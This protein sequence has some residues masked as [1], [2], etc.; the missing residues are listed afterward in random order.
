MILGG[1]RAGHVPRRSGYAVEDNPSC[2]SVLVPLPP[3]VSEGCR[4]LASGASL[5][6]LGRPIKNE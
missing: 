6:G 4:G 5:V 2:R 1:K 3:E